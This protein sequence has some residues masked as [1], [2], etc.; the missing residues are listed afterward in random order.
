[1]YTL[2]IEERAIKK[3]KAFNR[4]GNKAIINKI[5][6]LFEE[7]K[8][9]PDTG[10][11][12]PEPLRGD[13]SGYWSRRINREHRIIYTIDTVTIYSLKGH[14]EINQPTNKR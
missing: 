10:T 11:G 4:L 8:Q 5:T 9:H 14:Y 3:L 13:L 1:M 12:Q 6:R 7:L 2:Q